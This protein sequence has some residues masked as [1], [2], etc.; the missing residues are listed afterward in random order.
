MLKT[1][2][3]HLGLRQ[4]ESFDSQQSLISGSP[5]PPTMEALVPTPPPPQASRNQL[6]S[7]SLR[8]AVA[9]A[10]HLEQVAVAAV[11][12]LAVIVVIIVVALVIS[13]VIVMAMI[14]T[15]A[16]TSKFLW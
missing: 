5:C 1:M 14:A 16:T 12:V 15:N 9:V 10:R 3:L 11:V 7:Y 4:S 8:V 13:A 6:R 2:N